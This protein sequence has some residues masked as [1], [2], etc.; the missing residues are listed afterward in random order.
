MATYRVRVLTPWLNEPGRNDMLVALEYPASWTDIT[1]Q[2][3]ELIGADKLNR[4]VALGE[5]LTA[6]RVTALQADARFAVLW[7]AEATGAGEEPVP[8]ADFTPEQIEAVRSEVAA[9]LSSDV[10][11]LVTEDTLSPDAIIEAVKEA[12][13]HPPW[14]AELAVVVGQV[15]YYAGNLYEVIQAHMTQSDWPPDRV[16]ALFKRYYEPTDDPWPWVQPLGAHDAYPLGARVLHGGYVWQST[17][18]ANVWEPGSVGAEA[19]W[20]NLT[21]PPPPPPLAAWA[22]YTAY[23]GDNTAG[24]GNGDLVSYNGRRYRCWQTHTSQVG[25]E[26]PKTPALWLDLGPI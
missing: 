1:W 5:H 11:R 22:P 23:R 13:L 25:W 19:L 16:P 9:V 18:A 14:Q 17:I 20:K 8:P 12:V 7:L 4:L 3:D 10:A 21:P 2:A 24:A 26:P 6:E 15:Y